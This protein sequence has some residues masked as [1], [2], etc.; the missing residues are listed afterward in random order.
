M[1]IINLCNH[2]FKYAEDV[3]KKDRFGGAAGE[4][5]QQLLENEAKSKGFSLVPKAKTPISEID[6]LNVLYS[7]FGDKYPNL[8]N[9]EKKEFAMTMVPQIKIE[10][11][12]YPWNFNIASIHAT[13]P[14]DFNQY[15]KGKVYAGDDPQYDKSGKK[16]INVDWLW[17]A[18]DNLKHGP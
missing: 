10:T 16:Y 15:W 2:F 18:Y 7:L 4:E 6:C 11:G 3:E 12:Y 9:D 1:N 14:S 17:R 5:R 8:S 13:K